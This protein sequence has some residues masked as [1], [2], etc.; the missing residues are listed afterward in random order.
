[1]TS[2]GG[3]TLLVGPKNLL[4]PQRIAD[5]KEVQILRRCAPQDDTIVF[6]YTATLKLL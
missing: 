5:R 3:P 2:F 6:C 4:F 1:M